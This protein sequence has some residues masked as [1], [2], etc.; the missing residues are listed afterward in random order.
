MT[1]QTLLYWIAPIFSIFTTVA[2]YQYLNSDLN[3]SRIMVGMY[4]FGLLEGP[5][6]DLPN[7][8]LNF[9]DTMVSM[10]R[11]EVNLSFII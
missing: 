9:L 10:R 7:C 2:A 1:V 4:V 6:R 11:I 5:L 3:I 8:V